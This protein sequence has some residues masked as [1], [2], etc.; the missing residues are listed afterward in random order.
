MGLVLESLEHKLSGNTDD[1]RISESHFQF[2]YCFPS[3]FCL[4]KLTGLGR[5]KNPEAHSCFKSCWF[6]IEIFS[7]FFLI[8]GQ[9]LRETALF[10]IPATHCFFFFLKTP[11]LIEND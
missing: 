11:E 7:L 1:A 4:P 9:H 5:Y 6:V 10:S 2:N 8:S 3:L